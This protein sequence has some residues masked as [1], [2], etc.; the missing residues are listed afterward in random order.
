V[1]EEAESPGYCP[2]KKERFEEKGPEVLDL[3]IATHTKQPSRRQVEG[4]TATEDPSSLVAVLGS[5]PWAAEPWSHWPGNNG[6][7]ELWTFF[8]AA[9]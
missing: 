3:G 2:T 9:D 7:A 6:L 4:S 5:G 8:G 1:G